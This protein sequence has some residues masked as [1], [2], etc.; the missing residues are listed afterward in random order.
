[1]QIIKCAIAAATLGQTNILQKL[2]DRPIIRNSIYNSDDGDIASAAIQNGH[3]NTLKW[4]HQYDYQLEEFWF[5]DDSCLIGTRAVTLA[6][7][8]LSGVVYQQ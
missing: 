6:I 2:H 7:A 5:W 8:F 3:L 4:L 1:M